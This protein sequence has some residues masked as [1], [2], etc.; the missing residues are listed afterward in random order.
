MRPSPSSFLRLS[1]CLSLGSFIL[2]SAATLAQTVAPLAPVEP[3]I[4]Q[5]VDDAQL[6]TLRGNTHPLALPR[7]DRGAALPTMPLERML[8]VLKRSPEQDAALLCLLDQQQDKSSPNYHKWLKPEEFGKRFGPADADIQAVTSWLQSHGFEVARVS[9]GRTVIEFSGTTAM[10]QEA[11]HTEMHRYLV[12]GDP[13]WANA[14]DPQIPSALAPVVS[15]VWTLHDF[16]KM[17]QARMAEQRIEARITPGKHAEFTS[18]S[19]LHALVPADFDKIYNVP[20]STGIAGTIGIV[21]RSNINTQDIAYFHM[22]TSDQ[23]ST[24]TVVVNGPDPGDLGGG[25][26]LEA[27]LDAT[28]SSAVAPRAAVYLVVSAST[29][30]T[31]GVDLSELYIVDND[32]TDVMSESFG[33]CEAS[34][35]T[36]EAN[37][38]ASVAQQ[39]AAQGITYLVSSGDSGSAGCD[40]P[41]QAQ[42]THPP[43]VNV[44]AATPYN[45]AVGGTVFNEN[46]HPTT[47]WSTI[48]DPATIGSALSYIPENVWNESCTGTKCGTAKPNLWAGGGGASALYPKP[49]WQAGVTGIPADHARD[50]P[51]VSLS[52]AGHDPYLVCLAGSCVPDSQGRIFFAGVGGTSA[53]APAFAG[54]LAMVA[55]ATGSRLGQANYVLYRL[56]A[57]ENLTQ[58]NG[59]STTVLPA[60]T[61]VF[62]DV[63]VGN[64]SVPG[65]TG[66]NTTSAK[67]PST[68]GYDLATGLGSVNVKNLVAQWTSVAFQ[69][70]QTTF[71]IS[72]QTLVHGAPAT[73][74]MN[75]SP[76]SAPG[77]PS[78]AIWLQGGSPH[79][80]LIGDSTIQAFALDAAGN[81]STTTHTLAGGTYTVNAHYAGDGTFA[82]SDSAPPVSITVQPEPTTTTVSLFTSGAGGSLVPFNGGPYG[83]RLFFS[84]HVAGNSGYGTPTSYVSFVDNMATEVIT[85]YL[86]GSPDAL[87]GSFPWLSVGP[88]SIKGAYNGDVSFNSSLSTAVNFTITKAATTTTVQSSATKVGSGSSVTLT[89]TVDTTGGGTYPSGTVAFFNG[90]TQLPGTAALAP[91]V[92]STTGTWQGVANYVASLPDGTDSITAQYLDDA[93]YNGSTSSALTVTVAPDFS[94][95]FTGTAGSVMT[96]PAPGGSGSLTLSV[97]GGAGYS[98]TVNFTRCT[99]LP[100]YSN[101]T[102]NPASVSASGSTTLTVTTT[103]PH[104]ASNRIAPSVWAATGGFTLA[105][106]FVLGFTPRKRRWASLVALLILAW[107]LTTVGCGGSSSGGGGGGTPGTSP[108]TYTV[109]ATGA[110]S[111][112][113]HPVTFTLTVQ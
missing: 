56:A 104:S 41:T 113:S 62:N 1:L 27:V 52:A 25:E 18:S 102:F 66:Y 34:V 11:F 67:Y 22:W 80:T 3:R 46:G 95:A 48:N 112:F 93:N 73:L 65:E 75:V 26:E 40:D 55:G 77:T 23:A 29:S 72:P 91:G 19:G 54:I 32:L 76:V 7:F 63:T 8:L 53:S 90:A 21:G 51:D 30:T 60:A 111:N 9:K 47:Y 6:T 57:A 94:L 74:T 12:N 85:A 69:A 24:P 15:G 86:N 100:L 5:A 36:A 70:T 20:A 88:H 101:C 2:L 16:V 109:T 81:V 103:A 107:V 38:I 83:T 4:M 58:C 99:G 14:S 33:G 64:N 108:G 79:G 71:S 42:A 39:A 82:P 31:D 37:G 92:N 43:S 61:C 98:G 78:G 97:T 28:W 89:A 17:P 84:A 35:T 59:S 110:D 105:G 45:I 44:L 87:S 49:S 106:V 10:L 68:K 96:I 50:L 13:H